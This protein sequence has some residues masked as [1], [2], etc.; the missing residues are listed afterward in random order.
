MRVRALAFDVVGTLI[1]WRPSIASALAARNIAGA[2]ELADAW[3]KRSFAAQAEVNAGQR[4][5][6]NL[7][8]LHL[9]TLEELLAQHATDLPIE[10]RH[11]LVE[12]WHRL[13]AW[14]DAAAGL[15]ALRSRYLTAALSNGRLT[16][17]VDLARHTNLRFD[18]LLSSEMA[19]AYKPASEVYLTAA[20]LLDLQ[21][22]E[23]MLVS[24]HPADLRGG[25]RA[26]LRTAF[27]DRS[28]ERDPGSPVRQHSDAEESVADL[29]ELAEKLG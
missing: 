5:W 7:D 3:R 15:E 16:L 22:S 28:P 24:A 29:R 17:L 19:R 6:A 26:G 23:L 21:P 10:Q 25:R 1:E 13:P 27:V 2:T 18:C 11:E 4:P 20:R 12:A 14:P 9:S 8:A